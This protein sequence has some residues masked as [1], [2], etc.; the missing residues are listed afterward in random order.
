MLYC[1][2]Y[3]TWH[4]CTSLEASEAIGLQWTG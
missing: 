3:L 2:F 1:F 4:G